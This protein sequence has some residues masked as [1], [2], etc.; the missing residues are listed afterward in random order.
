MLYTG[1]NALSKADDRFICD[2]LRFA[3]IELAFFQ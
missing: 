3:E 1:A 2:Y